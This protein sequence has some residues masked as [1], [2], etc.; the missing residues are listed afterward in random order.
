MADDL[1]LFAK[2]N[3]EICEAISDVLLTFCSESEHKVSSD[4]SRI[5]F[6]PNVALELKE[7]V[8]ENLGML[9]TKNFGKYLGFSLRHRGASRK[10]FNFVS[11]KG[12]LFQFTCVIS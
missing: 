1:I 8:C 4:K 6:S 12:L 9:E 2:V 3:K 10:Q 7:S 5:Y 11:C